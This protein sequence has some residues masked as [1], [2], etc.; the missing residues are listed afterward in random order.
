MHST[1]IVELHKDWLL[2]MQ[3][4]RKGSTTDR[5]AAFE[6]IERL[7]E[8]GVDAAWAA[9][10]REEAEASGLVAMEM[11][12]ESQVQDGFEMTSDYKDYS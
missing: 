5:Y 12:S 9:R 2:H 6:L 1:A 4:A 3:S 7:E 11:T 10:S 8:L